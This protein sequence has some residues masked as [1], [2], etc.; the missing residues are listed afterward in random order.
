MHGVSRFQQVERQADRARK[1]QEERAE[2]EQS[3]F[4]TAFTDVEDAPD[5]PDFEDEGGDYSVRCF[6]DL[7]FSFDCLYV[8]IKLIWVS[9]HTLYDAFRL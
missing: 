5:D 9:R 4:L 7:N 8:H 2:K 6:C 1:A 3:I